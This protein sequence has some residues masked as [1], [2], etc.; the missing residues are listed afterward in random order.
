LQE[1]ANQGQSINYD[2][3]L[4]HTKVAHARLQAM[5]LLDDDAKLTAD[6]GAY[7]TLRLAWCTPSA[8]LPS[9]QVVMPVLAYRFSSRVATLRSSRRSSR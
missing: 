7:R 4:L 1:E 2:V 6:C 9:N 8:K 3:E 5:G